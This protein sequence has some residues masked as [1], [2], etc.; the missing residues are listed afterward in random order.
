MVD[1]AFKSASEQTEAIRQGRLKSRD[2]V[3]L[4]L[5]RIERFDGALNAVVTLDAATARQLPDEADRAVSRGGTRGR[6]HGIP[7]TIKDL[8][9]TAG[10]RT[11]AGSPEM[12]ERVPTSDAL[13][14]ARLRSAGAIIGFLIASFAVCISVV[15]EN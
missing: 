10:M 1:D 5:G 2:L 4:Y 15:A 7:V 11:T 3:E 8:I 13:A 6:L 9:D 12:R 14:V